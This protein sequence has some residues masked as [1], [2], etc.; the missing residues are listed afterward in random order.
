MMVE[1]T[2]PK[3]KA[4]LFKTADTKKIYDRKYREELAPEDIKVAMFR[5][6]KI[7]ELG[8]LARHLFLF[9]N[10]AVNDYYEIHSN[11]YTKAWGVLFNF[12]NKSVDSPLYDEVDNILA[13]NFSGKRLS[14][15]LF[16]DFYS[17][18]LNVA[19]ER[20]YHVT[21]TPKCQNTSWIVDVSVSKGRHSPHSLGFVFL[22]Q[23]DL[24]FNIQN[25]EYQPLGMQKL[26]LKQLSN[27][28]SMR[29]VPVF[30]TDYHQELD[31]F[32]YLDRLISKQFMK[33]QSNQ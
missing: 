29:I 1:D 11:P 20:N 26:M 24:A 16:N 17:T 9:S 28:S 3:A 18:V 2:K 6:R 22:L 25:N 10:V 5:R 13:R 8:K 27:L 15:K 23:E 33:I 4:S 14:H 12:R 19:L 21:Y 30:E 31:K 7:Q 32:D